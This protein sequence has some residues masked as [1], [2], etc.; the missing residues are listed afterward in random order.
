M[1][2]IFYWLKSFAS[3]TNLDETEKA[4]FEAW[5][6][7]FFDPKKKETNKSIKTQDFRFKV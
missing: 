5:I 6:L 7:N 3:S 2:Y 1:L 4:S